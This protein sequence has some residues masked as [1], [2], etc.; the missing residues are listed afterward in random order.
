MQLFPKQDK[1]ISIHVHSNYGTKYPTTPHKITRSD[2][3]FR[4]S[5]SMKLWSVD[6]PCSPVGCFKSLFGDIRDAHNSPQVSN[7]V[8]MQYLKR[9]PHRD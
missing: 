8:W 1:I 9:L 6:L 7:F 2:F 3:R 4:I 5:L